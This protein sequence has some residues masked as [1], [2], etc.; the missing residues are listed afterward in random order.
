MRELYNHTSLHIIC[1]L[2]GRSRQAWY[3]L[4]D[5]QGKKVL[6]SELIIEL[7][8]KIRLDLPK[9]GTI[10]LQHMLKIPFQEHHVVLGRDSLFTL[11]RENNL[12][13]KNKKRYVSTTNSNHLFKMWPDLVNRRPSRMPEEIWVSDITYLRTKSGFIYLSLVTDAY[14]RKIVGFH[15]SHNLKASGPIKAFQ[16]ANSGR[17]YPQRQ[18]IHHSDRGIQYCCQ[19]YVQLL[20]DNQV[21]ISMTQDGNPYDNAIAERVNGILKSEFGLS[22]T[23]ES[24]RIALGQV[25]NGIDKYNKK[26]PH[27]SCELQTPQFRH[28]TA[29]ISHTEFSVKQFQEYRIHVNPIQEYQFGVN[30][31]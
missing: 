28:S 20:Q 30:Y 5:N 2:F 17:L 23:F 26:R 7:V 31:I 19:D 1:G 15:L 27:F 22:E 14:S 18:L 9:T 24:Y 11:L 12:L 16:M 25:A 21:R 6:K 4:E 8:Q 29:L 3:H 10:K 13:I